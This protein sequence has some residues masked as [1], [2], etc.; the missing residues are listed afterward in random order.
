MM[1]PR[2]NPFDVA[3]ELL[4]PMLELEKAV[5][6]SGLELSLIHL[7]KTRA[8]QLNGCAHCIHM[9][10][11]DARAAGEREERLY[12]LSAWR[13][14]PLY[15]ARERAALEWTEALTLLADTHAPDAAYAELASQFDEAERVKLSLLIVAIN[16][17]N[18]LAVGFRA[19]HPTGSDR[20]AA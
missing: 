14:S 1:K 20:A 19:V 5:R 12:L 13:E 4:Q 15:T 11:R 17:W 10:T 8:S 18:R 6:S 9:H 16:G 2:L 7:V 3:P